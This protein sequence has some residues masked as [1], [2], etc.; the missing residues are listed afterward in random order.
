MPPKNEEILDAWKTTIEVQKHFN[1]MSLKIRQLAIT[2]L[3]AF[4]AA[5][6]YLFGQSFENGH[7]VWDA[8][9]SGASIII[10]ILAS[11]VWTAFYIN[12]YHGYHR[13]LLGAVLHGNSIETQHGTELPF[14][15]L[16]KSIK[17]K[18]ASK[19]FGITL[20]SERRI[21][22]FYI[23]GYVITLSPVW[24]SFGVFIVHTLASFCFVGK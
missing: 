15:R 14:I 10:S 8:L 1:E 16:T 18:S 13:L 24:L 5:Y 21:R 11:I 20:N 19:I 12:D 7:S 3:G 22:L 6:G 2:S 9:G 17:E 4:L 23:L